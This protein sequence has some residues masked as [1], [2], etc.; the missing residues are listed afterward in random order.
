[1]KKDNASTKK[2]TELQKYLDQDTVEFDPKRDIIEWWREKRSV[3]PALSLVA[4]DYLATQPTSVSSE[5]AFSS[6]GHVITDTRTRLHKETV[7]ELMCLK[8]WKRSGI[9]II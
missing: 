9:I 2:T 7:R 8:S 3:F 4:R 1:M 5:R 6:C